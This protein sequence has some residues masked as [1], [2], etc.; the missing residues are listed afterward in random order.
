MRNGDVSAGDMTKTQDGTAR[1]EAPSQESQSQDSVD[2]FGWQWS[3]RAVYDSLTTIYHR[4]FTQMNIWSDYLDG[5]VVAD[6]GSGT[7]RHIWALSKLTKA[8]ELISVELADQAVATQ[9]KILTD[10]RLRIIH[11][12]AKLASFKA[13]FIYMAGFIQH[14]EDPRAVLQRQVDNLND[15]GEIVVSFYMRTPATMALEPI[16]QITKRLPKTWLWNLS[17]LLVLPFFFR[18]S[19]IKAGFKNARHTAYDF[20]GS[21]AYQKYFTSSEIDALI[22]AVG[23]HPKNVLRISKGLY[24]LRKGAFASNLDD[25][26]IT[27]GKA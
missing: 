3:E 18:A 20:F 2:S 6:V 9:R 11:A 24:R 14:T 13:D 19:Q 23:I 17:P 7:G 16:R 21:H 8:T 12:D 10:P 1:Q 25:T 26:L 4:L 5:K 15:K 27:F 22:A